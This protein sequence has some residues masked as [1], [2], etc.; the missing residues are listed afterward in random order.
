M[1]GRFPSIQL[2]NQSSKVYLR[3][4]EWITVE[5]VKFLIMV[6]VDGSDD[7]N[8]CHELME[9]E[10]ISSIIMLTVLM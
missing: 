7:G 4:S 1:V 8:L 3:R 10:S 6:R 5:G 2:M 9:E